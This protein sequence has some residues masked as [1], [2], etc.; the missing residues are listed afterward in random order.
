M[1][2]NEIETKLS[3]ADKKA[4]AKHEET[5][6]SGLTSFI[7]VGRALAEIRDSR[8]HR[9]EYESFEAYCQDKWD[10][11]RRTAYQK[12]EAA[13]TVDAIQ[14]VRNYAHL[15]LAENH[16][17]ELAKAGKDAGKVWAEVLKKSPHL[18]DGSPS[19]TAKKIAEIRNAMFA[20]KSEPITTSHAD[21]STTKATDV[22][23]RKDK[24]D[25]SAA[26]HSPS[27]TV[28]PADLEPEEPADELT[29]ARKAFRSMAKRLDDKCS[30]L[31]AMTEEF[32]KFQGKGFKKLHGSTSITSR[33]D[34][35]ARSCKSAAANLRNAT[36]ET[37]AECTTCKG[38]GHGCKDC[39]GD[40]W[41]C[42]EERR[43][44]DNRRTA[45]AP[46]VVG[47]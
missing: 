42:K 40:G 3:S 14:S 39:G 7:E 22:P 32:A 38:K 6:R 46:K 43:D 36:P 20:A 35:A 10:L 16:A 8:L 41:Q 31:K 25:G 13:E 4:L 30:E 15:P 34:D 21:V 45:N 37:P 33:I 47:A 17:L 24:A 5:I 9:D 19:T 28:K 44:A 27:V 2:K 29:E 11:A 18:A 23:P 1:P 12:I 26:S